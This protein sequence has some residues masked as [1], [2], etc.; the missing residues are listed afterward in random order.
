[1]DIQ[2]L[3]TSISDDALISLS[4]R[5]LNRM[6][7]GLPPNDVKVLKQRRRT[8]KNRGYAANCREKRL[9][10]KEELEMERE[11]LRRE[12]THLRTA[13]DDMQRQ[14]GHW[15]HMYAQLQ[16]FAN[17]SRHGT[18]SKTIV[19]KP[20]V[21]ESAAGSSSASYAEAASFSGEAASG[22]VER[23]EGEWMGSQGSTVSTHS[24]YESD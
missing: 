9:T 4:V 15:Q 12:I 5:E 11:A 3:D 8:L 13:N 19:I 18:L 24:S 6:L 7:K 16:T 10:Q 1:M 22:A 17:R 23:G 2:T 14:V 21:D 20:E